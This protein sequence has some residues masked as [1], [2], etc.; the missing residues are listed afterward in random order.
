M[1]VIPKHRLPIVLQG[2]LEFGNRAQINALNQI[3]RQQ[4]AQS[5]H[6]DAQAAGKLKYYHVNVNIEGTYSIKVWAVD[7][8]EAEDIAED[9]FCGELD[10]W[11]FRGDNDAH[12][13]E[14]QD[15][16]YC[17]NSIKYEDGS[18]YNWDKCPKHGNKKFSKQPLSEIQSTRM[19][20]RQR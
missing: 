8:H 19:S 2:R 12:E 18:P 1:T 5:R 14:P 3:E 9:M 15:L 10:D 11:E 6:A 16:C 20:Q 17:N 4:E 13:T 7:E